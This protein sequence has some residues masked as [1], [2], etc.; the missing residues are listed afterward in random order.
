MT[1]TTDEKLRI[2]QMKEDAL[3]KQ[4]E[5]A[6]K[7]ITA[8]DTPNNAQKM[9]LDFEHWTAMTPN[10]LKNRHN[11]HHSGKVSS[12]F[13]VANQD[14]INAWTN[15]DSAWCEYHG[16][17]FAVLVPYGNVAVFDAIDKTWSEISHELRFKL[18]NIAIRRAKELNITKNITPNAEAILKLVAEVEK[19]NETI[20]SLPRT[21]WELLF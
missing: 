5:G 2:Q 17:S 9:S 13:K 16:R 3:I 11:I 19:L 20:S 1:T 14:R 6:L 7:K 4:M 18:L 8:G 10:H 15:F 12:R 21:L